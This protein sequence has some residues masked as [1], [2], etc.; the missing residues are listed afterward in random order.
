MTRK[1]GQGLPMPI[2]AFS[3]STTDLD[4]WV[5]NAFYMADYSLRTDQGSHNYPLLYLRAY[6]S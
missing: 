4:G 2:S 6:I 1:L 3:D 5:A